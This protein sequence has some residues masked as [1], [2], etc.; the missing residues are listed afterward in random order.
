MVEAEEVIPEVTSEIQSG[1][2]S[3]V[4]NGKLDCRLNDGY[5]A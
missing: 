2:F 4:W 3:D 5:Y 1:A